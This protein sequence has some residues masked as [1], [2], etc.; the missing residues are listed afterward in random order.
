MI[1]IKLTIFNDSFNVKEISHPSFFKPHILESTVLKIDIPGKTSF[2]AVSLYRPNAHTELGIND[3]MN[4]FID[5]LSEQLEFLS[6]FNSTVLFGGDF[7]IDLFKLADLNNIATSFLELFAGY[8]YFNLIT[9]ATRICNSSSTAIDHIFINDMSIF[10]RSGILVDSPSDHFA[11]FIELN[12]DKPKVINAPFKYSRDFTEINILRFRLALSNQ[13][14][15]DII[16]SDCTDTACNL[17]LDIFFELYNI[18]FPL[19]RVKLNKEY[20]ALN[21][22]MS[23]GLLISRKKNLS[24]ALKVKKNPTLVNKNEYKKYRNTYLRMVKLAKKLFING[25]IRQAG[26]NTKKIWETLKYA[27]NIPSKSSNI[28]PILVDGVLIHD[29]KLK[30]NGFNSFFTSIGTKTATLIPDTL[31]S[32]RDF[33]PPPCPNSM[34]L[35]PISDDI[36]AKFVLSIKPKTSTDINGISSKF[37]Q[38][39]IHEIKTPLAHVFNLSIS[40]G[41]FPNAFKTSKSIPIFKAGDKTILDNYRLVSL[42]NNFSKPYE[43]IMCSR[44]LDFLETNNFFCKTQFGFRKGMS[45]KHALLTIINHI[46]K[47]INSNKVT[48][49]VFVDCMKAFDTVDHAVLFKKLENAGIRGVV[50]DWFIS[51]FKDRKQKVFLNGE[52]SDNLCDIILGVLQGS[53]IGVILFLIMINDL[54]NISPELLSIIFADDDTVLIDDDTIEGLIDKANFE[55]EKLVS[56]YCA[57]RLAIHPS[58]T[59]CMLFQAAGRADLPSQMDNFYLP[60]FL[61]MN[62]PGENNSDKKVLIKIVPN[63]DDKTVKVLGIHLDNKLNFKYHVNSIHSKISR[64]IYTLKQMKNILDGQH[65]KLLFNSYI[66]SMVD[67]ADIFFCLCNKSTIHPIEMIYKKA[68]RI[69]GGAKYR[70]HTKPLFKQHNILPIKENFHFN[71]LKMMFRCD[72]GILPQPILSAWCRNRDISGRDGRNANKFYQTTIN[73]NYLANHPLFYYPKLYNDLEDEFK[74]EFIL[75]EKE[76]AK[77]VKAKL[78]DSIE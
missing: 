65:L 59:K 61:N 70:D 72:R 66:K 31:S 9:R 3:Q 58:K 37:I 29:N 24:L 69:V 36:F 34:F 62:N 73:I 56:W 18:F 76:F 21:P 22:F 67:Y 13:S 25:R 44:L 4:E 6:S 10:H 41:V 19:K 33:L 50:L 77:K 14:W 11:T 43:K 74:N 51:Y 78:F 45:T 20:H 53:V 60:V 71:I 38:S 7:N 26:S 28:G 1:K 30:A 48:L 39:V 68:I 5:L 64:G 27:I 12:I 42:I 55:L 75:T 54:S 57:N 17:F 16:N 63:S 46:S 40:N 32:F 49:L 15:E 23:K 35:N 2:I 8:G 47:N 52:F